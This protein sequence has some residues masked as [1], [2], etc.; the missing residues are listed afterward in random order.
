MNILKKIFSI[1]PVAHK[2]AVKIVFEKIKKSSPDLTPREAEFE[3][4]RLVNKVSSKGGG[5]VFDPI[6]AKRGVSKISSADYNDNMSSVF[7]DI[8]SLYKEFAALNAISSTQKT[9]LESEFS[10]SRA[11]VL[12]LISDARVF[13]I[14]SKYPEF[15]IGR[16]HV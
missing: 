13:A 8:S 9:V 1:L 2:D 15:E 5:K 12:K 16:A 11:A 3:A 4:K 7:I 6:Y 14:R 10:K